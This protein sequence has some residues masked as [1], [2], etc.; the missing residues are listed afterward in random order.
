MKA[1]ITYGF[2]YDAIQKMLGKFEDEEARNAEFSK[3]IH[4]NAL[5]L[6]EII[7]IS[8]DPRIKAIEVGKADIVVT[9]NNTKALPEV[10]SMKKRFKKENNKLKVVQKLILVMCWQ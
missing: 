10:L 6:S 7:E 1:V 2:D 3:L 5:K 9:A 4:E 8:K